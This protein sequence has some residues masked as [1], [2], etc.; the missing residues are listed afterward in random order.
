MKHKILLILVFCGLLVSNRSVAQWRIGASAGA[1]YN[2][3]LI[4]TQYQT[5]FRYDG[6]WGWNA[7]VFGQ[8]NF[9][10]WVGLRAELEVSERNHRLYRTGVY[11]GMNYTS[12]N[13][14][15]QL[16]VMT[17]FSFGGEHW[18]GFVHVGVYA[19]CWAAGYQKGTNYD[20][21][22][23]KIVPVDSKYVFQSKKDQR[24]DF[25]LAGGIGVEYRFLEH[26]AVHVE[27]RCYY[28][29]IS[30]VK[31]YMRVKDNRYNTTI[32]IQA[33]FSYIF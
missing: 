22:N 18:R 17:Q 16:P 25:G 27:G 21:L 23:D 3:Y 26:W 33:G 14:Y 4:N 1:D 15:V 13:I 11:S 19:G 29:F 6:A 2:W 24:A 5:D 8:Y 10:P 12:H 31:P 20:T 7:A 32:G 28:S 30:T 9:R